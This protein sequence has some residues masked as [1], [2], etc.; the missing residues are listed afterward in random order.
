MFINRATDLDLLE[1]LYSSERAEF[2]VLYGRQRVGKTELL[3]RFCENKR[4]IFFVAD[5][6]SEPEL[7]ANFSKEVN[8]TLFGQE[9]VSAV[10]NTWEDAFMVLARYAQSERLVVVLDEFPYMAAAH[11]LFAPILQR[12]WDQSLKNTQILL[13]LCGSNIPMMEETV[14]GNQ[15]P[16][17]GRRTAQYLLEPMSFYDARSFFPYYSLENQVQTYAIWG[18]TPAYLRT[19]NPYQELPSNIRDQILTRGSFLYDEIRFLLQQELRELRNY[20]AILQAIAN[21]RTRLKEIKQATGL[22][23]LTVY[24]ETL[25]QLLL[26]ERVIPITEDQPQKSRL[27]IYRLKVPFFRFWFRF[28]HSNRNY[29]ERGAGEQVLTNMIM[30][31]LEGFVGPVFEEICQQFIWQAGLNGQLPLAP[32]RV[33]G[34][35]RGKEKID[36]VAIEQEKAMLFECKWTSEAIGSDVLLG[37]ERKAKL[38]QGELGDRHI[39][40]GLC[41]RSGFTEALKREVAGREDVWLFD[42]ATIGTG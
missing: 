7:R 6:A 3:G 10:Y 4:H 29:L 30:P 41:A 31:Q 38:A 27:G 24:L 9:A 35:W 15:A 32:L 25:Q 37:L 5:L 8:N 23:G 40:L 2:F 36:L 33:G 12:L 16:L 28:V 21:G 14:L 26:V 11:P 17:Y 18:G 20:C 39:L 22:E 34:W 1:Q 42:L 19:L 13:I